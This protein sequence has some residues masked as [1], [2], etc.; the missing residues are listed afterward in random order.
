[1]PGVEKNAA[2]RKSALR[3]S[4]VMTKL[5]TTTSRHKVKQLTQQQSD[6]KTKLSKLDHSTKK[7]ECELIELR[8][9]LD[10]QGRKRKSRV[11]FHDDVERTI[12]HKNIMMETKIQQKMARLTMETDD[13]KVLDNDD[14]QSSQL[15]RGYASSFIENT[16]S[17]NHTR[18][19]PTMS[20]KA[21]RQRLILLKHASR[22]TATE[23]C[24][25]TRHCA[26]MKVLWDHITKDN[27]D[28]PDCS[29]KYCLSSRCVLSHY[30]R[31]QQSTPCCVVCELDK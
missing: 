19:G 26:E 9:K 11:T 23:N 1:M 25:V 27:C 8:R 31:C 22:C 29:V 4:R 30:Q 2:S 3:V 12:R 14:P 15:E 17:C 28:D 24:K 16:K 7:L 20:S 6:T 21:M 18:L 10:R 5:A 13:S